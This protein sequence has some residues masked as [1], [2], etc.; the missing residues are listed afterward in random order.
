MLRVSVNDM[1]I[2]TGV[3]EIQYRD[4]TKTN[5]NI[6]SEPELE[7]GTMRLEEQPLSSLLPFQIIFPPLHVHKHTYLAMVFEITSLESKTTKV[8]Y[9]IGREVVVL[10]ENRMR[11]GR[12]RFPECS[13][14]SRTEIRMI[15]GAAPVLFT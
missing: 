4:N 5:T 13:W 2:D 8:P 14:R 10:L 7:L 1:V 3:N 11:S 9:F 15:T 6:H 12:A